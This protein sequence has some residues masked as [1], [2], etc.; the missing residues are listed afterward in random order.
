MIPKLQWNRFTLIVFMAACLAGISL[1][2]LVAKDDNKTPPV[3]PND[4]TLRLFQV[5]DSTRGGKLDNFY[6]VAD[7]YKDPASPGEE[8]QHVLKV[9]YDK[10]RL[11]GKLQIV[12]RSVGKIHPDQMKAY[13]PKEFFEFGLADQAKFMKSEAGPFGEPGDIYLVAKANRP[14]HS[15]PITDE[16]RKEY[17]SLVT[18]YL[19]PAVEKK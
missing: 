4:P 7:V 18:K 19:I 16:V 15:V 8:S 9:E 10:A 1:P 2:S 17:E 5:A 13:T 6:V 3:D 11:F 12:V 14:L